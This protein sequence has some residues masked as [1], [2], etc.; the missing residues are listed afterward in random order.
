MSRWRRRDFPAQPNEL[1]RNLC[2]L[3]PLFLGVPVSVNFAVDV[4]T[5]CLPISI[6]WKFRRRVNDFRDRRRHC[7]TDIALGCRITIVRSAG[8]SAASSDLAYSHCRR[9]RLASPSGARR[10][11]CACSGRGP[12]RCC[13]PNALPFRV[14]GHAAEARVR[15]AS[16][17]S[18]DELARIFKPTIA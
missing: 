3:S 13:V 6:Q 12:L 18:S 5:N 17:F 4:S 7:S 11:T 9:N 14:A 2:E 8:P 16:E 1:S 10:L 15:W